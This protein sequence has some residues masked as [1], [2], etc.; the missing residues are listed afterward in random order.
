MG[1]HCVCTS[2]CNAWAFVCVCAWLF[3]FFFISFLLL[4]NS[5]RRWRRD[6]W[7]VVVGG[8]EYEA[9]IGTLSFL[10]L[11]LSLSCVCF[12]FLRE[13]SR[14]E[15][16]VRWNSSV[17]ARSFVAFSFWLVRYRTT[18]KESHDVKVGCLRAADRP[19]WA[20]AP[21]RFSASRQQQQQQSEEEEEEEYGIENRSYLAFLFTL[22][23][24]C[25][26][27]KEPRPNMSMYLSPF[28][29]MHIVFRYRGLYSTVSFFSLSFFQ[30]NK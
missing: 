15:G 25:L 8:K 2:T 9:V 28:D 1:I 24:F 11:S 3:L 10:S 21:K 27:V 30:K 18:R 29:T 22:G 7:V 5:Q 12:V 6:R 16:Q 17:G 23:L 19:T 13:R 20:P 4:K 14:L 26:L